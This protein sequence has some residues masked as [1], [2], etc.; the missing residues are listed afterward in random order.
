VKVFGDGREISV[1]EGRRT[2]P[3]SVAHFS[4]ERCQ[5]FPFPFAALGV[6]AVL[7]YLPASLRDA[8]SDLN[9]FCYTA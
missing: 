4:C 2:M 1:P 7:G 8:H 6:R 9:F 3:G 5:D